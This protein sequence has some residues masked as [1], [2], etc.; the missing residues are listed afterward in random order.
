MHQPFALDG[1]DELILEG[2][3]IDGSSGQTG[4]KPG[5]RRINLQGRRRGKRSSGHR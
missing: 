3:Q 4:P 1:A 2:E 5:V